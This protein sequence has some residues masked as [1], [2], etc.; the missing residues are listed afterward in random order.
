M[1][2][3]VLCDAIHEIKEWQQRAPEWYDDHREHIEIVKKVM[4]SLLLTLDSVPLSSSPSI[5]ETLSDKQK[6]WFRTTCEA[7]IARWAEHLRLLE[8]ITGEALVKKLDDAIQR[9]EAMLKERSASFRLQRC[10]D[11]GVEI[12]QPHV[13]E[14]D[15][16]QCTVCGGQRI[17]CG[18]KKHDP[19]KAA[20]TGRL[21]GREG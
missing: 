13:N 7:N 18:C 15:I 20:W 4:D 6:T 2:S 12:G 8:P 11:C 21:P 17:S 19:Q 10:P 3:D 5:A 9:Q 1:L 16:E 14:C